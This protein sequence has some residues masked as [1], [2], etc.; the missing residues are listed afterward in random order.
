MRSNTYA[1]IGVLLAV[2]L[3]GTATFL[4]HTAHACTCAA[5]I[6]PE[7]AYENAEAVFVGRVVDIDDSREFVSAWD[8]RPH[9]RV[10]LLVTER[11]KGARQNLVTVA[12][13]MGDGD[14]GYGFERE[15]EYLVY[16]GGGASYGTD[17]STGICNR[18]M[19]LADAGAALDALGPG[20]ALFSDEETVYADGSFPVREGFFFWLGA[21]VSLDTIWYSFF[22]LPADLLRDMNNTIVTGSWYQA[23]SI[24]AL[25]FALP[26]ALGYW[27]YRRFK[28]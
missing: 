7:E 2:V 10:D 12:T 23:L 25:Y 6:A 20:D 9:R 1:A 26:S 21:I 14:C 15:K 19:P 11:W 27:L 22:R 3:V 24:I 28:Q 8:D 13:G 5:G 16:A 18:T 17:L 4:P